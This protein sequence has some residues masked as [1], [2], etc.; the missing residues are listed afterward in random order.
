[1]GFERRR[2]FRLPEMGGTVNVAILIK[3]LGLDCVSVMRSGPESDVFMAGRL[4]VGHAQIPA[5]KAAFGYW[6]KVF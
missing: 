1:M 6:N 2:Y 3:G 5:F 4:G